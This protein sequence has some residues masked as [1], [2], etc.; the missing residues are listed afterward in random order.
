MSSNLKS[1]QGDDFR[2]RAVRVEL[3]IVEL[4]RD[5]T[6]DG[7]RVTIYYKERFDF[8]GGIGGIVAQWRLDHLRHDQPFADQFGIL[9]ASNSPLAECTTQAVDQLR[10]D[11]TLDTLEQTWLG[12]DAG[13]PVLQ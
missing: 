13:A 9:M 2:V 5:L 10:A 12:S 3:G 8:G 11:G 4:G 1:A 7:Q 6:E